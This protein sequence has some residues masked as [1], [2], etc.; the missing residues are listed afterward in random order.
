M[1]Y[2]LSPSDFAFLYEGCKRCFYLKV[3]NNITQPSTPLPSIFSKIA[4]LLKDYY[5]GKNTKE[6]HADLPPGTVDYGEKNVQSKDI[7]FPNHKVA[8]FIRGRFDIAI[9]FEDG[10]YGVVDFK[11]G[12]PNDEYVPLY[13]RQL[14]AYA[15]ALEN[16]APRALALSPITKMGLVYFYPSRI[17]QNNIERLFY[18]AE[19]KWV[20][21]QKD[22]ERFLEFIEQV[23]GVL[24]SPSP[25][26]SSPDCKWCKYVGGFR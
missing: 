8:C 12:H 6:L 2:R 17:E 16:A 1:S 21:I 7:Q 10:T 19:I 5:A 23:L 22:N 14:H 13:S 20:E 9:R 25:P 4:G 3:V 15:Y 24:E 26:A 11:T 18:E